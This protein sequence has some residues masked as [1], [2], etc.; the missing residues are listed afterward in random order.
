[1]IFDE[2]PR[3]KGCRIE[4]RLH[5]VAVDQRDRWPDIR[6]WMEDTQVRLRSAVAAVGGV[7]S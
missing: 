5:G 4:I 2:L 3:N 1:L 6:R 7:P